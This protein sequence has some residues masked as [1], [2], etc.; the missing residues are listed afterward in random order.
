MLL[1]FGEKKMVKGKKGV[2][3]L[4]YAL[5]TVPIALILATAIF[6]QFSTNID[7]TGWTAQAN[8]TFEK[9]T[10]GTWTGFNLAS[11]LPFILIALT[12]VGVIFGLFLYKK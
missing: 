9:V 3:D 10:G 4:I 5:L 6:T 8:Q 11:M 7:R 12:I 1:F 2:S